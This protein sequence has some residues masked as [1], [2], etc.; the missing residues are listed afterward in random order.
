M[1]NAPH[2]EAEGRRVG[3]VFACP[4]TGHIAKTMTRGVPK[5]C[6]GTWDKCSGWRMLM[7][8]KKYEV[9]FTGYGGLGAKPP[10]EGGSVR[11][12]A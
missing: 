6:P 12:A 10:G 5:K 1:D 7:I 8:W 2:P 9:F 11:L 4:L 3:V